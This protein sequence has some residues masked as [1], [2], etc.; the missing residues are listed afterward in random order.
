MKII[1][2]WATEW[3]YFAEDHYPGRTQVFAFLRGQ[4]QQI[5]TLGGDHRPPKGRCF[6]LLLVEVEEKGEE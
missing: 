2:E 5:H 1:N 4:R 6:R 3:D